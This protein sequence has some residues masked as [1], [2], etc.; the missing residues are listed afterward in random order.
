MQGTACCLNGGLNE[1]DLSFLSSRIDSPLPYRLWPLLIGC[2]S[3]YSLAQTAPET[4]LFSFQQ[5]LI[6]TRHCVRDFTQTPLNLFYFR[7]QHLL[8]RHLGLSPCLHCPWL[9]AVLCL[10][11]VW[12][13]FR[14]Q[15]CSADLPTKD[16]P[17]HEF[18]KPRK[19]KPR[20]WHTSLVRV[21]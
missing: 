9:R 14:E 20:D 21:S 1:G 8:P 7:A 12:P 18:W 15:E 19:G 6:H 3:Q 10:E 11:P 5:L 4:A 13:L 16:W 2:T 17:E